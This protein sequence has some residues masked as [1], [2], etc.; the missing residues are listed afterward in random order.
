MAGVGIE[1]RI[2]VDQIN[3]CIRD[4]VAQHVRVVAIVKMVR[5]ACPFG[6]TLRRKRLTRRYRHLVRG[7]NFAQAQGGVGLADLGLNLNKM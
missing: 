7:G 4:A 5:H 3:G 6:A 1:G 2:K